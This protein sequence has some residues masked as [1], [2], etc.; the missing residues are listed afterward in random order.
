MREIKY[1]GRSI[2][3][4]EMVYGCLVNNMWTYS[5]LSKFKEGTPVCEIITGI[6]ESDNWLEAIEEDSN[7]VTV[8]PET[9]GEYTGLKDKNAIE[10]YEGDILKD[11]FGSLGLVFWNEDDASFTIEFSKTEYQAFL[12]MHEW[13]EVIGNIHE[14]PHLL[15]Q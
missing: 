15:K 12:N 6:Y 4:G 3:T 1:R 14:H 7:V 11:D 2:K 13:A 8:D 5:N 9:V 10:I